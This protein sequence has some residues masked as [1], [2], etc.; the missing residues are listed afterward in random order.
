VVTA[1]HPIVVGLTVLGN[2]GASLSA[3]IPDLSYGG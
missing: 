1:N 3:A 2:A